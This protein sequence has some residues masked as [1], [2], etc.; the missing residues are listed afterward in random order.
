MDTIEVEILEDGT[1]TTRVGGSVSDANHLS[2][3][4]F[5][6]QVET[7]AGGEVSREKIAKGHSHVNQS[8]KPHNH[9]GV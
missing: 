8:V 2:A 5:L 6:R 7:L 1:I 3:D 9:A 4:K